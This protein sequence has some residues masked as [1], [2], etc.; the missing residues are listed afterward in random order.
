[1]PK[2]KTWITRDNPVT[3]VHLRKHSTPYAFIVTLTTEAG[4]QRLYK[5][6]SWRSAHDAYWQA[7]RVTRHF[8]QTA[9]VRNDL[10]E[11][12]EAFGGFVT[13]I[14][15]GNVDSD[16]HHIPHGECLKWAYRK[17]TLGNTPEKILCMIPGMLRP[18]KHQPKASSN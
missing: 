14:K 1:V 9:I 10:K 11:N 8:T 5:G 12:G 4:Q 17:W 2:I 13:E 15:N 18:R 6:E 3:E 16:C 7:V